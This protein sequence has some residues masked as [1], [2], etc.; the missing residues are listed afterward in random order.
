MAN[1]DLGEGHLRRSYPGPYTSQHPV[2][3]TER[4]DRQLE[5]RNA[6]SRH[7]DAPAPGDIDPGLSRQS[8]LG[9][10]QSSAEHKAK[11]DGS[12][13]EVYQTVNQNQTPANKEPDASAYRQ[14]NDHQQDQVSAGVKV[15]GEQNDGGTLQSIKDGLSHLNI[16]RGTPTPKKSDDRERVVTDPITHLPVTIHDRTSKEL[17]HVPENVDVQSSRSRA[18]LQPEA[19]SEH[20]STGRD[21]SMSNMENLFPPPSFE[22]ARAKLSRIYRSAITMGLMSFWLVTLLLLTVIPTT[23]KGM[24]FSSSHSN[25]HRSYTKWLVFSITFST[26]ILSFV[27][28]LLYLLRGWVDNKVSE[29]WQEEVWNAERRQKSEDGSADTPESTQWLNAVLASIWPLVNPDL[30]TSLADK[31]EV[32]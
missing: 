25:Q 6:E 9:D 27:G 16:L 1:S 20:Q 21:N 32:S 14:V 29:V 17:D 22:T 8:K 24:I 28:M 4:Y 2:P 3:T 5:Q 26:I 10:D 19:R 13:K 7:A 30:F 12:L 31:L 15:K 11:G 23:P 18:S